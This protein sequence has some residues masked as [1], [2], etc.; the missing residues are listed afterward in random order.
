MLVDRPIYIFLSF[1]FDRC[2]LIHL[3]G[4]THFFLLLNLLLFQ[5][6]DFERE[7]ALVLLSFDAERKFF[8]L[9]VLRSLFAVLSGTVQYFVLLTMNL[10]SFFKIWMKVKRTGF[11]SVIQLGVGQPMEK[12][13]EVNSLSQSK[14]ETEF[15]FIVVDKF[16]T[17]MNRVQI[18]KF[19]FGL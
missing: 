1:S 18:L 9:L 12:L 8:S 19:I 4:E 2:H 13:Y 15:F 10:R 11:G 3:A 16:Y 6:S 14:K 17:Q 5:H 7:C